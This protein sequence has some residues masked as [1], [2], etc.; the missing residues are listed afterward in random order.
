MIGLEA[1]PSSTL[2]DRALSALASAPRAAQDLAREV[3]GLPNAPP[4]VASRLASAL[5]GADPRVSQLADGRWALV[6]AA[7]GSPLLEECAFAVVDVETTGMRASGDRVIEVGVVVV[8]GARRERVVDRL[9]NPGR[10]V[11]SV[12]TRIT[13][14]TNADLTAAPEF[15]AVADE[16]LD[17]LAGRVFVAHNV[18]FDWGFLAAELRRARGIGLTGPRLCTARL[19][20]RLVPEAESCGLDWLSGYFGLENPARHRALGDAWATA[21]LLV[22][23]LD[24]ARRDGARTLQDLDALQRLGRRKRG[25]GRGSKGDA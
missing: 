2:L 20:R 4:A 19:A 9:I 21:D 22:R 17:A 23:L 5:L 8:Q 18:R 11:S 10:H 13:R 16:V 12:I 25:R 14:I 24:R 3:M 7:Q 6:P 1:H 15:T